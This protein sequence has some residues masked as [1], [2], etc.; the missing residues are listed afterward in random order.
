MNKQTPGPFTKSKCT[1]NPALTMISSNEV[2]KVAVFA[3]EADADRFLRLMKVADVLNDTV[4]PGLQSMVSGLSDQ[5][6]KAGELLAAIKGV[7]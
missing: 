1:K 7:K 3:N 2:E 5:A 6:I 4:V